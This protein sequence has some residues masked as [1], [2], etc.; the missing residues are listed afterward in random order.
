MAKVYTKNEI[1][2]IVDEAFRQGVKAGRNTHG[3]EPLTPPVE[4][5]VSH[6]MGGGN[7]PSCYKAPGKLHPPS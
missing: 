3:V 1:Q 4:A 2:R 7:H 5:V 6:P